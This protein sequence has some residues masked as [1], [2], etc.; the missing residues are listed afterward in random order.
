[1]GFSGASDLAVRLAWWC[2]LIA[3][4]LALL[5]SL[6][7]L[8]L[9]VLRSVRQRRAASLRATW[10]PVLIESLENLP[11]SLP[12]IRRSDRLMLLTLWN[13]LHDSLRDEAQ[14]RLNQVA[15]MARL[16]EAARQMARSG[17]LRERLIG[18]TTLGQLRDASEWEML[19][20]LATEA[21]PV[22]SLVAAR[23]LLRIDGPRAINRVM[24]LIAVRADWSS[25]VVAVMLRQ[26]GADL[27]SE[28]LAGEALRVSEAQAA[29]LLRFGEVAHADVVLPVAR[30]LIG[31]AQDGEVI[32]ACL[33][34]LSGPEDLATAR[35]FLTDARWPV[36]VQAAIMLGRIG[37]EEDEAQLTGALRDREWW[38]RYRAA[39]ALASLPSMNAQRLAKLAA[40]LPP[41]FEFGR[42][43]IGQVLAERRI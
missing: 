26:A 12:Q 3:I 8:A 41:G 23:A 15:R 35:H 27:V 38:V 16:D 6:Q 10:E 43:S 19:Q 5:L 31:A 32:T 20:R 22:L 36:R 21:D 17:G 7:L 18:I 25:A 24:P 37:V 28:P 40:H 39:Q 11:G 34:L 33:R 9:R 4:A 13:Y 29:R 1:M 42:D 14:E 2:G 30:Q